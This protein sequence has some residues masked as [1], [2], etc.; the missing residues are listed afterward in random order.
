MGILLCAATAFAEVWRVPEEVSTIQ[1]ALNLTADRDTISI[2]SGVYAE[3][4]WSPPHFVYLI[5]DSTDRP[6]IDPS[7]LDSARSVSCLVVSDSGSVACSY[8][9]FRSGAEM[10]P[11]TRPS[12][13]VYQKSDSLIFR[14]CLFDSLYHGIFFGIIDA[15]PHFVIERCE[16]LDM[17]YTCGNLRGP[18]H[19]RDC[20]IHG[21]NVSGLAVFDSSIIERCTFT[22]T[23]E[24]LWLDTFRHTTMVRDNTFGPGQHG[25]MAVEIL[26]RGGADSV[27][28]NFFLCQ[29]NKLV[30]QVGA[31]APVFVSGNC[32]SDDTGQSTGSAV[33]AGD[34]AG[35]ATDSSRVIIENNVIRDMTAQNFPKAFYCDNLIGS[36]SLH[37]NT[38]RNLTGPGPAISIDSNAFRHQILEN[39]IS[40]TGYALRSY[41][42]WELDA[43]RNWWGDTT[44]PYHETLN[45]AGLGD[46]ID[47]QHPIDFLPWLT[48]T[49]LWSSA[50]EPRTA[51]P[52]GL[53]M[54][55]EPNPA[56]ASA[57]ITL[58]SDHAEEVDLL[59][60]DVL[61]RESERLWH[62]YV[63]GTRTINVDL[64][65]F[66]SGT[67]FIRAAGDSRQTLAVRRL[68][69][70]K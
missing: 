42:G 5:G 7:A 4:L 41:S 54:S 13:V 66:A 60:Y 27:L 28:N 20:L 10:Y 3:A 8:L 50:A 55:V 53:Q 62:G 25:A 19:I 33:A 67:Y 48:D 68:T 39:L 43:R 59:I 52:S 49:V 17:R 1:A 21:D 64:A 35:L 45:P 58:E 38:I 12:G 34:F 22:G 70:L 32:F 31:G 16:F 14:D 51:L 47:S 40:G 46:S 29:G 24:Y 56:N 63:T 23:M 11:R 69:L 6:I 44:G 65:K 26:S 61:G 18:A 57:R 37:R 30:V 2:G 9:I 15:R 36:V